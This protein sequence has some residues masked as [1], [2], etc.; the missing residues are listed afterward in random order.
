ME[1]LRRVA[2]AC[3]DLSWESPDQVTGVY[4]FYAPGAE[5][6]EEI[7][8]RIATEISSASPKNV[9]IDV[10]L[11]GVDWFKEGDLET[12]LL[13]LASWIMELLPNCTCPG[14]VISPDG[15]DCTI[16]IGINS[17]NGGNVTVGNVSI[18]G[19]YSK[20]HAVSERIT[21]PLGSVDW[22]E[23]CYDFQSTSNI[24]ADIL[25]LR[26]TGVGLQPIP[27]AACGG[28]NRCNF[29][30][31][32]DRSS[33]GCVDISG[34]DSSTY[35]A[36]R[37]YADL[38]FNETL[39]VPQLYE[40]SVSMDC[41]TCSDYTSELLFSVQKQDCELTGMRRRSVVR[42]TFVAVGDEAKTYTAEIH[43]WY[44]EG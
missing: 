13:D 31:P 24:R 30:I 21:L 17:T 2:A 39:E 4:T 36:L 11:Q 33:S 7:Y 20:G 8:E 28:P 35:S 5:E 19:F 6:L 37:L 16:T 1:T 38:Y 43:G 40:W 25:V 32:Y 34:L 42:R 3:N 27:D 18:S 10:G 15:Q 41:P 22:E 12:E 26:D 14:C 23:F 29:S 44:K 9:T